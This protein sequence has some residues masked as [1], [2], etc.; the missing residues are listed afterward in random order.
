MEDNAKNMEGRYFRT[1]GIKSNIFPKI[2][3]NDY[4]EFC[5]SLQIL[6]TI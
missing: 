4:D 2:R 1:V 3:N 6:N 5:D